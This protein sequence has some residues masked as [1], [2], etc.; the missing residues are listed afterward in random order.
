[1]NIL[2][3]SNQQKIYGLDN[4]FLELIRLYKTDLYPNKLLLSGQKGIGKSTLAYHFINYVLSDDEDYKYNIKNFEINSQSST[5]KTILNKSNTNLI[6]VDIN[7]DKKTIDINQIRELIINLNK[8][9]FNNKPRFVLIDNIEL[10]NVNSIN[11][12]LKI[13]E[14]PNQNIH[15]IL[16]NNNKKILNTLLSRCINYKI[17]LSNKQCLEI[18]DRLLGNQLINLINK[19]IINYYFTPGNIYNLLKFAEQYKYDLLKLNLKD[20]LK[21]LIKENHYKKDSFVKLMLF[22]LMEFYFRKL[23]FPYSKKIME[24]YSYFVRKISD[25]KTFNL[26]EESLFIEF[27]EDVLNG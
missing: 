17:S 27:E 21:V 13:L 25:T 10:L 6:V 3:P 24:K 12:L 5:F 7:F 8:S 22:Q 4:H 14:E 26:D 9:S 15:F 20:F 18:S 23:N 19:D 16:I 11:A 1:M 2:E